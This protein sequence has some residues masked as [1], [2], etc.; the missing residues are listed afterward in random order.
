MEP[1][2]T[3]RCGLCRER[4]VENALEL[5][6]PAQAERAGGWRIVFG[7]T[8][9]LRRGAWR[10][11][12]WWLGRFRFLRALRLASL[13]LFLPRL[14][15]TIWLSDALA[16][17]G[18]TT[19][20]FAAR[21]RGKLHAMTRAEEAERVQ[22]ATWVVS[23]LRAVAQADGVTSEEEWQ[24]VRRA[25]YLL[26]H[27]EASLWERIDPGRQ[28]PEAPSEA[29]LQA[30]LLGLRARLRPV[31]TPLLLSL[32]AQVAR[33]DARQCAREVEVIYQCAE[34]LGMAAPEV[35]AWF[36]ARPVRQDA[37]EILGLQQG[38]PWAEV[39]RAYLR[40]AM[41]HHPDRVAHLGPA[42]AQAAHARMSEIN[43]AYQELRATRSG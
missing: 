17:I 27:D 5:F 8:P 14:G 42:M 20:E 36:G 15:P 25:L 37:W 21:Q 35:E 13:A 43:Q 19:A 29:E 4:P 40:L 22:L 41:E 16:A 10:S 26:H 9:C 12:A 2:L 33:T 32:M 28:V 30:A 31:D 3:L 7:C 38:A 39:R 24:S 11:A 18:L 23:L 1:E 34:V 6:E